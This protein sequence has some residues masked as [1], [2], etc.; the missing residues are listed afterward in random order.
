MSQP[1]RGRQTDDTMDPETR[2]NLQ[3]LSRDIEKY[4]LPR[5]QQ[6]QS[7]GTDETYRRRTMTPE[8][9]Q[10]QSSRQ[11]PRPSSKSTAPSPLTSSHSPSPHTSY[12]PSTSTRHLTEHNER[13]QRQKSQSAESQASRDVL[14]YLR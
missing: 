3:L 2:Q 13:T 12:L 8:T 4:R 1:G 10:K 7:T 6:S 14:Q 11:L 9:V 5:F